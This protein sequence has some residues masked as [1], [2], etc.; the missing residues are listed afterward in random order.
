MKNKI[1]VL[2]SVGAALLLSACTDVSSP[3][4]VLEVAFSALK[5]ND[6]ELFTSTLTG[7]AFDRFGGS[8]GVKR[9]QKE[10]EGLDLAVGETNLTSQS[11][12]GPFCT[13]NSYEVEIV[14]KKVNTQAITY[15]KSAEVACRQVVNSNPKIYSVTTDCKISKLNLN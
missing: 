7:D 9:L 12:C 3:Q 8:Q 15:Q 2:C 6:A 14:G 11:G 13:L 5:T 4:G 10:L 1:G